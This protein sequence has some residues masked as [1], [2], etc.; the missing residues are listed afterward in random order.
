MGIAV[1]FPGQGAQRPGMG[2][3]LFEHSAAA[4]QAFETASEKV[5]RSF[6]ELCFESDEE[7]LKRTENAQPALLTVGY[8]GWQALRERMPD[9]TPAYF[10]GHSMGEYTALAA[11]GVWTFEEALY[12]IAQR[13][14]AM[15]DSAYKLPGT[16]VALLGL[17]AAHVDEACAKAEADG[18]GQVVAA[19]Y[20]SPGQVVISGA[21]EAVE[22]AIEYAKEA[23]AKRAIPLAVA[24]AFHSPLMAEA[25]RMISNAYQDATFRTGIAPVVSNVTAKPIES[26]AEWREVMSHQIAS[27]VR[28]Q[29]SVEWMHEQGVD[30]F[31]E[32]GVGDVLSGLIKRIVPGVRCLHVVDLKTLEETI[33]AIS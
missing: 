10:A 29:E 25:A 30:T 31:I 2:R 3:D 21:P 20:N 22:R 12:W 16:M 32:I 24:G 1:V 9:F 7:T 26:E 23:G 19:N 18:L 17:D 28:W 15:K 14:T 11:S 13:A 8:A 5:G 4:R 27:P 6:T 33:Q